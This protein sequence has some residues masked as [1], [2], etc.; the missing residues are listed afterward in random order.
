MDKYLYVITVGGLMH[1]IGKLVQRAESVRE[2]HSMCGVRFL[3]EERISLPFKEEVLDVI[4]YHH[5]SELKNSK[6][7]V[8][9]P[10]YIVYEADN[11]ASGADRRTF[12]A[13][14]KGGFD[15]STPLHAVFNLVNTGGDIGRRSYRPL[16]LRDED[17]IN[18]P[19]ESPGAA[20]SSAEYAALLRHLQ[21]N[22][23]Q[24]NHI[25]ESPNSI[26]KLLEAVSSYI[27]SS[28]ALEQVPD[29]SLFDHLKLTAAVAASIYLYFQE[30]GTDDYCR[31][32]FDP[33]GNKSFRDEPAFLLASGDISGIQDFIYTISSKGALKSLRAR[34]FYLEL[35]LEH[36]ADEILDTM[37]LSRANLLYT[38]GG[39]FYMLLPNTAGVKEK[40][41]KAGSEINCWMLK[42]YSTSLYLEIA[43]VE[44][45]AN[46]FM[47]AGPAGQDQNRVGNLFKKTSGMLSRGKTA[48]YKNGLLE[49]V[50]SPQNGFDALAEEGRE[51]AICRTSARK[52]EED[53]KLGGQTVCHN[54]LVLREIGGKLGRSQKTNQ[55]PL[56]IAVSE[57]PSKDDLHLE[58]PSLENGSLYLTLVSAQEAEQALKNAPE[59]YR[60]I[61]SVNSLYTGVAYAT[62][63]WLGLYSKK[64]RDGQGLIE[65]EELADNSQG[66][67]RL[68]V[69]R[70]DVDNLGLVFAGG[71]EQKEGTDRFKYISLSRYAVLSRQ[72][73]L[74]FKKH[75]NLLCKQGTA[76]PWL[77]D[78]TPADRSLVIVYSGGDDLFIVGAWNE[79]IEFALDL[80][81][82][83]N[84]FSCGR[85]NFSAGIA[86][87]RPGSP[88]SQMAQLCAALE[89]AAKENAGK[90]SVALFGFDYSIPSSSDSARARHLFKWDEF[91]EGVIK[92]KLA[93]LKK[94]ICL[95]NENKKPGQVVLG[96]G[97]LYRWL[98]LF[99]EM[100]TGSKR[101]N[102][103]RLAY[104]LARI[105]PGPKADESTKKGYEVLWHKLYEWAGKENDRKEFITALNL[106]VYQARKTREEGG[107]VNVQ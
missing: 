3:G 95:A 59:H 49:E 25:L 20:V 73:S 75:I 76:S 12:E 47:N 44:A 99:E 16:T 17:G 24:M 88:I 101:I 65:F 87:F 41:E 26:L 93:L 51:C 69:M 30:K 28:T 62:N 53:E 56:M 83:F 35:M 8:S 57:K 32:C 103:A 107:P 74:F 14:Q 11:I 52:L 78:H 72:L 71:L 18:Y 38:G 106:M 79:V 9:H 42:M 50:L 82:S 80:K 54:C 89:S 13:E 85:L 104:S 77:S 31:H 100:G 70:A 105:E 81:R 84:R 60:R 27:P 86:M 5:F 94:H 29:I 19:T 33:A 92:S 46:D 102:L 36:I 91:S 64:P 21:D 2:N 45:S 6:L 68:A 7:P 39:H 48:R 55:Q 43:A 40:L 67:K 66:I 63:L 23:N 4:R 90:D 96:S 1:D 58:M 98:N 15:T 97:Q 22:L 61:Y 34:S 37:G 10:A